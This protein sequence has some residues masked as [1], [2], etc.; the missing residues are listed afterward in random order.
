[1][2]Y[3]YCGTRI[4]MISQQA[5]KTIT[6]TTEYLKESIKKS[7]SNSNDKKLSFQS[8]GAK[9][10]YLMME[11]QKR[12]I[13]IRIIAQELAVTERTAYRYLNIIRKS[14]VPITINDYGCYTIGI[15]APPKRKA[16]RINS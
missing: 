15:S 16:I 5:R 11:L 12:A 4:L 14:N 6:A 13:P 2:N 10:I 7:M 1:M 3:A 9:C 8:G